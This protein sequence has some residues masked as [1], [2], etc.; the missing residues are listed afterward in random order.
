MTGGA[1]FVL[2]SLLCNLRCAIFV[3][4]SFVNYLCVYAVASG[5]RPNDAKEAK[6]KLRIWFWCFHT[7]RAL[8]YAADSMSSVRRHRVLAACV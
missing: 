2:Q 8:A 5:R 1:I 7:N 4:Q 3:V 6:E